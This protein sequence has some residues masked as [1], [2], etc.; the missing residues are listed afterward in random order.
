MRTGDFWVKLPLV[1]T[2]KHGVSRQVRIQI[3][4]WF[5]V[6]SKSL[7]ETCLAYNVQMPSKSLMESYKTCMDKAYLHPDTRPKM[8]SYALGDVGIGR[9]YGCIR[10]QFS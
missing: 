8:I 3:V 1:S 2:D 7:V 10:N 4:D 5:G 9:A 6:E